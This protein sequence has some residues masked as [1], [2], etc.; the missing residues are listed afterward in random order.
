MRN[1]KYW[2]GLI[3]AFC[4][5]V[6]VIA[7]VVINPS[8]PV[9]SGIL[10]SGSTLAIVHEG[11]HRVDIEFRYNEDRTTIVVD[12]VER[13]ITSTHS[14]ENPSLMTNISDRNVRYKAVSL[15]NVPIRTEIE[16]SG[17]TISEKIK[18]VLKLIVVILFVA[19]IVIFL[20]F[21]VLP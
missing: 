15:D 5:A 4:L 12:G 11:E 3:V 1:G 2:I 7:F 13:V 14:F 17:H 18:A 16:I 21:L 9:V 6:G 20:I 8:S 10:W 19:V